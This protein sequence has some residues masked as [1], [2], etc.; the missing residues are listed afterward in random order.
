MLFQLEKDPG[1]RALAFVED[2]GSHEWIDRETLFRKAGSIAALLKSRG[3]KAGEPCVV[4]LPAEPVQA[5]CVLGVL[6]AGALPLLVAP[7]VVRGLHSNLR[8]VLAHVVERSEA[9]LVVLQ[10]GLEDL[11]E[12]WPADRQVPTLTVADDFEIEGFDP[13]RPPE[14]GPDD[15]VAMQLTSGTTG[16][17]RICVWK[18][19]AMLA[20]LQG[21]EMAMALTPEDVCLNWTPLYHD[22][23]LVNNFFLCLSEG[24]PLALVPTMNFMLDPALWLRS[25][26]TVGA[27]VTWS[28][29][30]GFAVAEQRIDD[31]DL[32][33]VSLAGV[34][35]FW[36]AA[37]RIHLETIESFFDRF[38]R[39]GLTRRALKTNFPEGDFLVERLDRRA[40]YGESRA[41]LASDDATDAVAVV[42]VG[43]PYPGMGIQILSAENQPLSDGS[44]GDIALA[45]PSRMEG[46][47]G[48]EESNQAALV[49]GLLKTGDLGYIRDGELFWVGRSKEVIN[50][51]G[52]KLD[53]SELEA[54]LLHVEGL[55]KGCFAAF[56]VADSSQGTEMLVV[57]TEA[58]RSDDRPVR[59]LKQQVR[60]RCAQELGV[61]VGEVLI[62][63]YGTM[64]KTSSGKRRHRQYQQLYLEGGLQNL[65]A[66]LEAERAAAAESPST[67]TE[68][69][70]T[71]QGEEE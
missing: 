19:S 37:E 15:L 14:R 4:V 33:G 13:V 18:Q 23:G 45:T 52:E 41:V 43:R 48:D 1:A 28:P 16:F 31:E 11:V 35:G 29:N 57:V 53:P 22:M 64:S 49:N 12:D 47:L 55:R 17:P 5:Y 25:L 32:E 51:H 27:T 39:F 42:G 7:P 40:L 36:N 2:D 67:R 61:R 60:A 9:S 24:V 69:R 44:V 62:L 50:L 21:M 34:R 58:A 46:Y 10:E 68:P 54:P 63:P 26:D 3:L 30:F 65:A 70:S 59:Q 71:D 38:E 8:E 6:W 56:G 66:S 20:A